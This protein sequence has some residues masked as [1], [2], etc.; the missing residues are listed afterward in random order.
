MN[1]II[2]YMNWRGDLDTAADPFNEIDSLILSRLSYIPFD[3][4]VSENFHEKITIEEAAE[5]FLKQEN[6]KQLVFWNDDILLAETVMKC[7]R[8]KHMRLS[9]YVNHVVSEELMQFSAVTVEI[10]RN[11]N[12]IAFRG[13]DDTIVGWREDFNMS[14][15]ST[16]PSQ[17][18][19]V[20]YLNAAAETL[21]GKLILG[22]HSKGGNLAVY[23]AV[24]SEK[25]IQKRIRAVYNNDGPGF[26]LETINSP[27][28][29]AVSKK[30]HT[31]IPQSSIV[32]LL[33]EHEENYVII[34]SVQ[35]GIM[36]HD[37]YSWEVMGGRFVYL[38]TVTNGSRFIDKTLKDWVA[39]LDTEQ[40]EKFFNCLFEILG[41][42]NAN[43]FKKMSSNWYNSSK[44]ILKSYQ[45][46]DSSLKQIISQ[47]LYMLFQCAKNNISIILPQP[48]KKEKSK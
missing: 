39:G 40:R 7:R 43:T 44:A 38:D 8:F 2:D 18:R 17:K 37:I 47:T 20:L 33:L 46:L 14:F 42:A 31:F 30:I 12:Y 3:G 1:N 27:E 32:G 16:V 6:A 34:H 11:S 5:K 26:S 29:R 36:Q 48:A 22:G 24:F 41:A 21:P 4:I 25:N 45:S 9:G 13:T 28:Y 10:N 23:S 15:L 35:K 19:A